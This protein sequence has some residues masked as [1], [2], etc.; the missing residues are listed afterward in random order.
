MKEAKSNID[1]NIDDIEKHIEYVLENVA[2]ADSIY[3][4]N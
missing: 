2:S 3:D 4:E 1:N